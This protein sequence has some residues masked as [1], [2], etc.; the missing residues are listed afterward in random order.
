MRRIIAI[1]YCRVSSDKQ[2]NE[3]HG[4]DGQ[5]LRCRQYAEQKGYEVV[6]VFKDE[7][8]SGGSVSRPG[9]SQLFKFLEENAFEDE[10][11]VLIDDISR[12]ARD[13]QAHFSLK[14]S[15]ESRGA[16]IESPTHDF[17]DNPMGKFFET[18][19]AGSA[20]YYRNENRVRVIKNMKSRVE[21]GYWPFDVPPGYK[22]IKHPA[23]GK[24]LAPDEPKASVIREALLG[25]QSRRF[26]T[27]TDV[28]KFLEEKEFTHRASYK[29]KVHVEQV[30]RLLTRILYAGWIEYPH[31]NIS[32]RKG[33]HEG[34]ITIQQFDEIQKRLKETERS[35]Q[36]KDAHE[37]FPLRNYLAC[38]CCGRLVTASWSK[39]RD[40]LY[41]YYRCITPNCERRNKGLRVEKVGEEFGHFVEHMTPKP[42]ALKLVGAVLSDLWEKR[43]DVVREAEEHRQLKIKDMNREVDRLCD[44]LGKIKGEILIRKYESQIEQ[45]EDKKRT[46]EKERIDLKDPRYDFG[47]AMQAVLNFME[48]PSKLWNSEE[49]ED[50]RTMLKLTVLGVLPY[51]PQI[52]FGTARFPLLFELCKVAETDKS[53]MVEM[54][55]IEPGSNVR[56]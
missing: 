27:Q 56:I 36:R 13:V 18:I 30:H 12:L 53:K 22:N 40:K 11:V 45:L 55:G 16:R 17:E 47:T 39:G 44:R 32:R 37:D 10:M 9:M 3:G 29:G 51:D 46:L 43:I 4:L 1:I 15:I 19:M 25:F 50:K 35:P 24:L 14:Q 23:H 31:W 52:G 8:V 7:G 49:F 41:P 54:P 48:N 5:E 33:H 20:E 2:V 28:A 34:L 6:V 21:K 38:S 26:E 42:A